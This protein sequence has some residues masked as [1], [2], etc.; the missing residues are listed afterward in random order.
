ML[1]RVAR[2]QLRKMSKQAIFTEAAPRAVGPYSQAI[3]AGNTLYCSGSVGIDP[4]TEK[5]AEGVE[6]QTRQS[7]TNLKAVIE[8]AG[9]SMDQVVKTTVLLNDMDDFA[10]VNRVYAEFF[11]Q[12]YPARACY[13]VRELPVKAKVEIEAIAICNTSASAL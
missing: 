2:L 7:L 4:A 12:P 6:A 1:S 10:V 5:M 9:S 3:R 11:Q 8:A 13:A